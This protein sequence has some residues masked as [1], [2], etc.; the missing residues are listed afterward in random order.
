[1]FVGDPQTWHKFALLKL[2]VL[3]PAATQTDVNDQRASLMKHNKQGYHEAP[4]IAG[5]TVFNKFKLDPESALSLKKELP[6]KDTKDNLG[7]DI[8]GTEQQLR[9]GIKQNGEFKYKVGEFIN[10]SAENITFLRMTDLETLCSN[11]LS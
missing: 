2:A 1:M 7:I 10:L 5:L 8:M 9:D 11:S 3:R 6:L 4:K